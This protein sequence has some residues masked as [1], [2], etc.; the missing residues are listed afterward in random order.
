[1]S[2]ICKNWSTWLK[3]T[4][5]SYM[6]EVQMQQTLNWLSVIRDQVLNLA[7]IKEGQIVADFGCGSGLLGFGVIEKFEDKVELIFSDK[8][9]DCLDECQNILNE[10]NCL[11]KVSFLK[12]DIADIKLENNYLDRAMTRSV[13]VH[14]KEKQPAFDE[15]YR[16]LKPQ[17]YYCAF[18]PIISENTRYYE[19]LAEKQI[20]DYQDFK[21]AEKEFMENINDPLVNFNAKSLEENLKTSGFSEV[22][23]D[24]QVVASKYSPS[25]DA[26]L[27]WFVAPPAP[28]QKTMKERFLQY[29]EEKKVD[30]FILEVQNALADKEIKVSSNTALIKAKK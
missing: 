20:S 15:I 3:K 23:I 25:K 30:N 19:L 4:R 13:L 2:E 29:F 22:N 5:F 17:G 12:S 8:F 9:Q 16:V 27:S 1:M 24:I 18:E 11:Y 10:S 21:K 28:D 26:I 6:N 14:V 7:D